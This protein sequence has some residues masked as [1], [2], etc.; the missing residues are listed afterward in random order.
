MVRAPFVYEVTLGERIRHLVSPLTPDEVFERGLCTEAVYGLL[1]LGVAGLDGMPPDH[2]EENPVFVRFLHETIGDDVFGVPA[3]RAQAA[4][5]G[6]GW[7]YI[8]DARTPDPAGT[9]PNEDIIGAVRVQK[10]QPMPLSYRAN[11]HH[12]LYT[13]A[14]F[15]QL[16]EELEMALLK[17]LRALA[18]APE[19][20]S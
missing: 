13:S 15:F 16:P 11:A 10:Q 14:G 20:G 17:R 6:D 18:E 2:F 1:A 19:L 9:V 8:L 4:E 3:V 5:I 12:R 7:L